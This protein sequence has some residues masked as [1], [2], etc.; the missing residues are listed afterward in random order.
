[1]LKINQGIA[2]V[3]MINNTA[4][5]EINKMKLNLVLPDN[6]I[7]SYMALHLTLMK[8]VTTFLPDTLLLS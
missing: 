6:K 1:M 3:C 4:I 8:F 7:H 2:I 5:Q